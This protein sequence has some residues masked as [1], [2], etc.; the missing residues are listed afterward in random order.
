M[1]GNTTEKIYFTNV[2]RFTKLQKA[3]RGIK[4]CCLSPNSEEYE[5]QC[6]D[7]PYFD[8]DSEHGS[9]IEE[10]RNDILELLSKQ[11]AFVMS[12]ED[13][14]KLEKGDFIWVQFPSGLYCFEIDKINYKHNGDIQSIQVDSFGDRSRIEVEEDLFVIWSA[15]PTKAQIAKVEWDN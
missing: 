9:C 13:M 5:T 14:N 12:M 6:S 2:G 15:K 4:Q 8:P 10:L 3:R 1:K 7:C 11:D